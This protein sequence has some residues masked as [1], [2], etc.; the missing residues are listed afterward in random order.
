MDKWKCHRAAKICCIILCSSEESKTSSTE[1]NVE[2]DNT[3]KTKSSRGSI[4]CLCKYVWFSICCCG[5]FCSC[6]WRC[7]FGG[8]K[9]DNNI[10]KNKGKEK[11]SDDDSDDSDDHEADDD[12]FHYFDD[13]EH[14]RKKKK[15]QRERILED[16][17]LQKLKG[18]SNDESEDQARQRLRR[19]ERSQWR[20]NLIIS[21][22]NADSLA[23]FVN[24]GR[25]VCAAVVTLLCMFYHPNKRII[26]FYHT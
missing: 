23:Y 1:I 5:I 11:R 21:W 25:F 16:K 19:S 12:I 15:R 4:C 24:L 26:S 20:N 6:C 17:R 3:R 14:R 2:K 22:A 13:D 10:N 9:H 7:L 18:D 8:G